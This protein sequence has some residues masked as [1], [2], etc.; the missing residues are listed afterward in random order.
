MNVFT[1]NQGQYI[2]IDFIHCLYPTC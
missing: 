1:R 2:F